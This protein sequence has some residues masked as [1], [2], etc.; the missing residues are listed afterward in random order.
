M[1]IETIT[2]YDDESQTTIRSIAATFGTIDLDGYIT[3]ET[4]T[5][6]KK[7]PTRKIKRKI[8]F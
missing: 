2:N 3:S 1:Q 6:P 5:E 4:K 7:K 8:L